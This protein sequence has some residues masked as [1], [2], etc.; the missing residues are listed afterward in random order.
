MRINNRQKIYSNPFIY[1]YCLSLLHLKAW[2]LLHNLI[3]FNIFHFILK[4]ILHQI[5]EIKII[6]KKYFSHKISFLEKI[7]KFTN[8]FLIIRLLKFTF[9]YS[10]KLIQNKLITAH[11]HIHTHVQIVI[12]AHLL[13]FLF[14]LNRFPPFC[15]HSLYNYHIKLLENLERQ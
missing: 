8:N 2:K 9:Y 6:S 3:L 15:K 5:I 1:L 13:H 7:W 11:K 10:L 14:Q 12:K 4:I